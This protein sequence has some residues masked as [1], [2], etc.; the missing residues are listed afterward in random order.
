M[1]FSF[2]YIYFLQTPFLSQLQY[3]LSSGQTRYKPLVGALLITLV[4]TLLGIFLSHILTLPIR[5]KALAWFPSCYA[6]MLATSCRL[7]EIG[8]P[9]CFETRSWLILLAAAY[10]TIII[11]CLIHPEAKSER[12]RFL[13]HLSPNLLALALFFLLVGCSANTTSPL[14]HELRMARLLSQGR[15]EDALRVGER[16]LVTSS[17]L[18]AMRCYALS[19][20]GRLPDGLFHYAL[21]GGKQQILPLP[22]DTLLFLNLPSLVFPHLGL[23]VPQSAPNSDLEF[24]EIAHRNDT[25]GSEPLRQYL[26]TALLLDR[27]LHRFAQVIKQDSCTEENLPQRYR[28][29]FVL[30]AKE[31]STF[32]SPIADDQL[33]AEFERFLQKKDG[34]DDPLLPQDRCRS[35]FADTYWYYYFFE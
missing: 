21:Q 23:E 15:Y 24:L 22:E 28:E 29:A 19:K 8:K 5:L 16:S 18:T 12:A 11:I 9:V 4:L 14:Q 6:L 33:E 31:D 34:A 27:K 32:I 17:R 26:L 10:L 3:S 30:L 35:D 2:V 13:S 7:S 25:L 20:T 1:C